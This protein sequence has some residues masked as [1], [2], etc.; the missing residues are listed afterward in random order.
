MKGIRED[1][2]KFEGCPKGFP[3]CESCDIAEECL[4]TILCDNCPK[5]EECFPDF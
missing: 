2:S 3:C 1:G 5:F 4:E